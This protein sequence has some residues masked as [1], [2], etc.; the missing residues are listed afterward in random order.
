LDLKS[1]S[2]RE[3]ILSYWVSKDK[4]KGPILFPPDASDGSLPSELF[5]SYRRLWLS[6]EGAT[7]V[8]SELLKKG[9][10]KTP[11]LWRMVLSLAYSELLWAVDRKDDH[12]IVHSWV[13]LVK[14]KSAEGAV[15]VVNGCLRSLC[16]MLES[17]VLKRADLLPKAF[18]SLF[19]EAQLTEVMTELDGPRRQF[20]FSEHVVGDGGVGAECLDLGISPSEVISERGG[21]VQNISAAEACREIWLD[22]SKRKDGGLFLDYC[23]APGGKSRQLMRLGLPP[24]DLKFYDGNP[25][26]RKKLLKSFGELGEELMANEDD[27]EACDFSAVLIDVPCSNSGVLAKCPEAIKHYW[28]AGDGFASIQEELLLKGLSMLREGGRLYYSTCSIDPIEN[29]KR[30]QAFCRDFEWRVVKERCWLPNSGGRHGAYLAMLEG[31]EV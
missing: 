2:D 23:A 12:G 28:E 24:E 15:S 26:R 5:K 11:R 6:Y 27:L 31:C 22:F 13:E 29:E 9:W 21:F 18:R 4:G 19:A 14:E 7:E 10:G 25:K 8:Y 1:N 30:V 16:R 17:G 3:K 20:W